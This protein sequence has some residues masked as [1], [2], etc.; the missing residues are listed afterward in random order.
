MFGDVL[1]TDDLAAANTQ[2]IGNL[3]AGQGFSVFQLLEASATLENSRN[4]KNLDSS[5]S[6]SSN[7][8]VEQS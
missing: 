2:H 8:Y 4:S 7:L 5:Y 6:Y 3:D 1:Y